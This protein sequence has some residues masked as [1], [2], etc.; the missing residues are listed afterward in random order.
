MSGNFYL[1]CLLGTSRKDDGILVKISD[2]D[3][4]CIFIS[5]RDV[6]GKNSVPD[7]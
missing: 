4:F 2:I 5:L 1:T 3:I 7:V 6:P